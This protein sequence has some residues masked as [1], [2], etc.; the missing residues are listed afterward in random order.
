MSSTVQSNCWSCGWPLVATL[1]TN[2]SVLGLRC[3]NVHCTSQTA[4][5]PERK[6]D[7]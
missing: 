5:P 4:V 1:S 2:G 6:S 3:D 7:G